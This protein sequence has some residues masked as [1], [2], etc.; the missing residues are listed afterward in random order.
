MQ[1][2]DAPEATREG[3]IFDGWHTDKVQES[4]Y[5]FEQ[6]VTQSFTLYAHWHEKNAEEV[7]YDVTF[8][9]NYSG[10]QDRK[11]SVLKDGTVAEP[12]PPTVEGRTFLGWF[13]EEEGG[14]SMISRQK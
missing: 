12:Q 4:A 7:Y 3:Y 13:T 6:A 14:E 8:D 9:Y 10:I 5:D 1:E 11:V 2:T